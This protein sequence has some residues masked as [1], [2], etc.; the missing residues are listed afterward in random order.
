M[1]LKSILKN[2]KKLLSN[3]QFG[4]AYFVLKEGIDAGEEDYLLWCLFALAA[5]NDGK[6]EEGI[7]A[8]GRAI[9]MDR[10]CI[11]AWQGLNKLYSESKMVIDERALETVE[12]LLKES[13]ESKKDGLMKDKRRYLIELKKWNLLT[14][15]DLEIEKELIPRILNS[16][17]SEEKEFTKDEENTCSLCFSILGD[18]LT[19]EM[20]LRKAIF[21]YKSGGY[22]SWSHC[23]YHCTVDGDNEWIKEKRRLAMAIHYMMKQEINQEWRQLIGDMNQDAFY[24]FIFAL[25]EEDTI[26]ASEILESLTSMDVPLSIASLRL[27]IRDEEYELVLSRIESLKSKFH[28]DSEVCEFLVGLEAESLLRCGNYDAA[29]KLIPLPSPSFALIEARIIMQNGKDVDEILMGK[30]SEMDRIRLEVRRILNEGKNREAEEKCSGLDKNEWEDILLEAE[31]VSPSKRVNLLVKA[32]KLNPRCSRAFFLLASILRGKNGAK[33]ISLA[34]RATSIRKGDEEYARLVDELMSE[35]GEDDEKRLK[36]IMSYVQARD[37]SPL[38]EWTRISISR[39]LIHLNRVNDAVFYLQEGIGENDSSIRWALLGEAYCIRGQLSS[40]INAYEESIKKE[41]NLHIVVSMLGVS[42]RMGDN[43]RTINLCNE[44]IDKARESQDSS[45]ITSILLILAQSILSI[46]NEDIS[47]YLPTLFIH[48]KELFSL[49]S[50]SSMLY[51]LFGDSLVLLSKT[52]NSLFSS[53]EVPLEWKINDKMSCLRLSSLFYSRCVGMKKEE[54]SYWSDLSLSLYLQW[55]IEGKN[56]TLERSRKCLIHAITLSSKKKKSTRSKLWS[57]LAM[58]EEGKGEGSIRI[59]HCLSRS[60]QLDGRNDEAWLRLGILFWKEGEMIS[61]CECIENSTKWNPLQSEG[62]SIWGEMSWNDGSEKGRR[63]GEDMMRHTLSL[64]PTVWSV[65]RYS[66]MV[67]ERLKKGDKFDPS[68]L[69]ID[70]N[71]VL[72]L[73]YSS[74]LSSIEDELRLGLLAELCGCY[75]EAKNIYD[76]VGESIHKERNELKY[77]CLPSSSTNSPKE[78]ELVPLMKLC[79]ESTQRLRE[80]VESC[81]C[82]IDP[83]VKEIVIVKEEDGEGEE[84]KERIIKTIYPSLKEQSI[85]LIV[86]NIIISNHTLDD[87]FI[88]ALHD[89]CPRDELIDYFP[90]VVPDE[91]DNG[92]RFISKDGDEPYRIHNEVARDIVSILKKRRQI[93]HST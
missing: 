17:V 62:W 51:K 72:Q 40:S 63:D 38:P 59:R 32:A 6:I 23:V 54:G 12:I 66:E 69:L 41:L 42:L 30:M 19:S 28:D 88:S 86:S 91:V 75:E 29:L 8:Y 2:G 25:A 16:I 89:L 83:S 92:I 84:K 37:S 3:S 14:K 56:E 65:S 48:I 47:L 49:S 90:T 15:E 50:P 27:L 71:R 80:L 35:S 82:V 55:K 9:K 46:C 58:I 18:D 34:E 39:L 57:Y 26:T 73:K 10:K 43:L 78:K 81:E 1:D 85:P 76:A 64:H 79:K 52:S 24:R 60:I 11:T 53:I 74:S 70:I 93:L 13:D 87:S 68:R 67:S 31:C 36:A 45:M 7:D 61:A 22:S 4:D 21:M 77:S 44:W 5:S 33:A 20:S